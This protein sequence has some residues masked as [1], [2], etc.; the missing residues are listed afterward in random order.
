MFESLYI[1]IHVRSIYCFTLPFNRKILKLLCGDLPK[2]LS[3]SRLNPQL[4]IGQLVDSASEIGADWVIA[5]QD[6]FERLCNQVTSKYH[7]LHPLFCFGPSRLCRMS[8]RFAVRS[9]AGCFRAG[10]VNL[11]FAARGQWGL[12]RACLASRQSS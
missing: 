1:C 8:S 11:T 6:C 12:R 9:R 3:H 7:L 4:A 5:S 2:N 10:H